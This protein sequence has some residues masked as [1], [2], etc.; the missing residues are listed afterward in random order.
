MT[1]E[2]T[3]L[4]EG[5][6][7]TVA[8][9]PLVS[10]EAG[11]IIQPA[12]PLQRKAKRQ[13]STRFQTGYVRLVGNKWYGRYRRD[14]A[15]QEDRQHPMVVLGSKSE[16]TKNQAKKKLLDIIEKEGLNNPNFL[17]KLTVPALTF[18]AVADLWELKRLPQL[19]ESSR[20]TTPKLI[21]KYLRPFFGQM[22][23]EVIK[24]GTVNG[25]IMELQEKGL[26]PKTAKLSP[27]QDS[28]DEL[29]SFQN[30]AL[31]D[32]IADWKRRYFD[33]SF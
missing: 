30:S 8:F 15:G 2:A 13:M 6:M 29:D 9:V 16:M 7:S 25:W 19:K 1:S 18:N 4:L 32:S 22:V 28:R 24:T 5:R 12:T 14:V 3:S 10:T 20:Y 33:L 11:A 17:E 21:A 27:I 26:A 23:L 31:T